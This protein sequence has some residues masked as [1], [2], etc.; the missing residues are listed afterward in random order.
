MTEWTMQLRSGCVDDTLAIGRAIGGV[1]VAGDVLSLVG[2]LGAGKTHLVKGI[3]AGLG[4]PGDREVNSP[5]FV[6][7]NEYEGRLHI[8]HLDAYRV[9]DVA[10]FLDLGFD[11]MCD[12][13]NVVVVEWGDRVRGAFGETTLWIE[14]QVNGDTERRV[15][16]GS[17]APSQPLVDRMYLAGLDEWVDGAS[18]ARGRTPSKG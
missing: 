15:V 6:L 14:L 16:L 3:A 11:E 10:A 9:G 12:G 1:L 2:C 4:V 7:L 8:C 13:Q 17:R 5:T 18:P